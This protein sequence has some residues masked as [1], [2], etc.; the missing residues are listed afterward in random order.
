M[1]N[2]ECKSQRITDCQGTLTQHAH[3]VGWSAFDTDA[4]VTVYG[5]HALGWIITRGRHAS[6]A[7]HAACV[8]PSGTPVRVHWK[9][10]CDYLVDQYAKLTA[11]LCW[12]LC[13]N[14]S[15]FVSFR[16]MFA[17]KSAARCFACSS[18]R[19]GEHSLAIRCKA[20]TL[21]TYPNYFRSDVSF[22][23]QCTISVYTIV[24]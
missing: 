22:G 17:F 3:F 14:S 4:H 13:R 12:C 21:Y 19:A 7:P 24:R 15:N 11:W 5:M 18:T 16:D 1:A 20:W 9:C 10:W 23:D 2:V 8:M 6:G